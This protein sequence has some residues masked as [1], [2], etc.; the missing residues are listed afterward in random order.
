M[1]Y[2]RQYD[3]AML[4]NIGELFACRAAWVYLSF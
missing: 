3:L 1:N 2:F 4:E